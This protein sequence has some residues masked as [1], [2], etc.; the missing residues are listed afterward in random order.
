MLPALS[1]KLTADGNTL[2]SN[3]KLRVP[4]NSNPIGDPSPMKAFA[5]DSTNCV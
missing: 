5:P 2:H 1:H 3:T 4:T